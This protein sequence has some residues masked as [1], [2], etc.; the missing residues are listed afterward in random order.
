MP[1]KPLRTSIVPSKKLPKTGV[2][3]FEAIH[4][5]PVLQKQLKAATGARNG[6]MTSLRSSIKRALPHK[7]M[8]FNTQLFPR[9]EGDPGPVRIRLNF[10][11]TAPGMVMK[12]EGCLQDMCA[13]LGLELIN[14]T[15]MTHLARHDHIY[16]CFDLTPTNL[17]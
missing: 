7:D 9:F 10:G 8:Y 2:E 11:S 3:I 16:L 1:P 13:A 14:V 12:I 4:A 6:C 15:D 5:V 17:Y